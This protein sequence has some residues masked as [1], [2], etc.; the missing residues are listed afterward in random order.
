MNFS[1]VRRFGDNTLLKYSITGGMGFFT[2][3][4]LFSLFIKLFEFSPILSAFIAYCVAAI[5]N[6]LLNHYWSF[7]G[8]TGKSDP[9]LYGFIKFVISSG[10][11]VGL[12]LISLSILINW[13]IGVLPSQVLAVI[14]SFIA[15][16][17]LAKF[18]VYR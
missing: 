4:I 6:Y 2:N 16:Y 13:S 15:N 9:N 17:Y 8:N 12:N 10:V 7:R 5:Q 18:F 11:S 3:I 14:T 1:R